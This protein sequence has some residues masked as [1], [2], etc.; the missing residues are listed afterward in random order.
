MIER[1][2]RSP[3]YECVFLGAFETGSE[4]RNGIGSQIDDYNRRSPHS[5]FAGRTPEKVCATAEMT[6][7]LA[8]RKPTRTTL[9]EPPSCLTGQHQLGKT[10]RLIDYEI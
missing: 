8:A 7:Q 2:W 5:T 4:A 9:A 3:K 10:W 6:E 1:L